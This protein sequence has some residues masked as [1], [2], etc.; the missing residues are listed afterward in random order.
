MK[1]EP[2]ISVEMFRKLAG[3]PA[4]RFSDDEIVELING[5]DYMAKLFVKTKEES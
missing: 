5:L 1:E 2:I 4:E 3:P